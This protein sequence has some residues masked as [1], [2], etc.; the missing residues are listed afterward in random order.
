MK[1]Y[2]EIIGVVD[3]FILRIPFPM[4]LSTAMY[5]PFKQK[6]FY[7]EREEKEKQNQK[8]QVI[9]FGWALYSNVYQLFTI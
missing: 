9:Q 4:K 7:L 1:I 6:F 3:Y 5:T 8:T 2:D